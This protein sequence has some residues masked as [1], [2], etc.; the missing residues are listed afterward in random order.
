MTFEDMELWNFHVYATNLQN[1]W[2][3]ADKIDRDD[4]EAAL[5]A[6]HDILWK[7]E[8]EGRDLLAAKALALA[9]YAF[10]G[11][12]AIIDALEA[13]EPEIAFYFGDYAS[14]MEEKT[15]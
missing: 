8:W 9:L 13:L 10:N 2:N 14:Y 4:I 1:A 7:R 12:G 11:D 15:A 5:S 6:L 3:V